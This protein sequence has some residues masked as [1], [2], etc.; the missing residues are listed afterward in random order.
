MIRVRIAEQGDEPRLL[1]FIRD[2]WSAQHVFVHRPEVFR[3]QHIQAGSRLNMVVAED[4]GSD[5]PVLGVLGFIPMG[6]FDPKLGDRDLMLAIWKVKEQ[7]V[8]P[9]V[10]LRLLKYLQAQLRPRLVAAIGTS[11]MVRPIYQALRYQVGA[12][13][14]AALFHPGRQGALRVAAHVPDEAF[15][16]VALDSGTHLEF[17]PLHAVA[18]DVVD[19]IAGAGLPAK[20]SAYLLE[21][22][23]DHPWYRYQV[24]MVRLD[25]QV[26]GGVVWRRVEAEGTAVL[27]VVDV[28]G[29]LEWVRLAG[30]A[31]RAEVMA[32]DAEYVDVLHWG[33]DES[34]LTAAGFVSRARYPE[35]VVP[36]YFA[37][38]ERRNVD[39]ELAY[40]VFED[41]DVDV[42]LF[43]ADSDQDRPNLAAEIDATG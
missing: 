33:I 5:D 1:E 43:R 40:R 15:G 4:T 42:R 37:P 28:I 7:G 18:P 14:H 24:R 41:A 25:G 8:P 20:S 9:G 27:R 6:R 38:F 35:M 29:S 26:V 30:A 34:A 17:V 19:R 31:F 16:E 39:I 22:Y 21:R 23:V 2:H 32:A 3:W 36:N 13:Q 11:Q 10:G 12:L